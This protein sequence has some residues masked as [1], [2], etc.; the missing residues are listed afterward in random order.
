MSD[1]GTVWIEVSTEA[2]DAARLHVEASRSA[3][4]EPDPVVA[5]MADA[6]ELTEPPSEV[7]DE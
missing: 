7:S 1:D 3:G 4:I 6:I 2:V 5:M